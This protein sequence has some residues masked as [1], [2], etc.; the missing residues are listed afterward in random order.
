[1]ADKL[2][3][4]SLLFKA[5]LSVT[6]WFPMAKTCLELLVKKLWEWIFVFV[7]AAIWQFVSVWGTRNQKIANNYVKQWK[8]VFLVD[9]SHLEP[10]CLC[11]WLIINDMMWQYYYYYM[12]YYI[13]YHSEHYVYFEDEEKNISII[14]NFLNNCPLQEMKK[15][16]VFH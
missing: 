10:L 8:K 16:I 6:Q 3:L 2:L 5:N 4:V 12:L 13:C 7:P 14:K 11:A 1:M 15:I 9:L